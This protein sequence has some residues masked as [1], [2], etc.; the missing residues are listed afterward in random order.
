VPAVARTSTLEI[1]AAGR[2]LLES[3]GLDALTMQAVA[4][5]I[6]IR[7]PSL[8]KRVPGRNGLLAAL[9]ADGYREL[10]R[11]IREAIRGDEPPEDLRRAA[12]AYRAFAHRSPHLYALMFA[13]L[14]ADARAPVDVAAASAAPILDL[15]TAWLGAPRALEAARLVTAFAHGFVSMELS[16]AFRLGGEVDGAWTAGIETL[17]AG[18][19]RPTS[20]PR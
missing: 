5:R 2:V 17:I 19:G 4:T 15:M 20:P 12:A 9:A 18:F 10:E 14:P 7:G 11:D 16:G 13:P 6:G 8:Y 3:G 1:V